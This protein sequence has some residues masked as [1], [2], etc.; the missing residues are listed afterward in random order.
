MD[1]NKVIVIG[2]GLAGMSAALE[3]HKQGAEVIVLE[4]EVRL[5]GNSAKAS[6]GT[7]ISS[8]PHF[9]T[10][11]QCNMHATC[12][13]HARNTQHANAT[14]TQTLRNTQHTTHTQT[15]RNTQTCTTLRRNP[16]YTTRTTQHGHATIQHATLKT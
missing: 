15:R 10:H 12:T 14:D 4:K 2:G 1:V 7:N 6:S 13:Q 5:G 3:A 9:L 8:S 16:K 11:K